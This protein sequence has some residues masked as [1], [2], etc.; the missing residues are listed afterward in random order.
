LIAVAIIGAGE[1]SPF[2]AALR[3]CFDLGR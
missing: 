2:A 3:R 1:Q